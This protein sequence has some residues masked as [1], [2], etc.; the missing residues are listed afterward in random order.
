MP[1]LADA[2][3]GFVPTTDRVGVLLVL[4]EASR[5]RNLIARHAFTVDASLPERNLTIRKWLEEPT[6]PLRGVWFLPNTQVPG[7]KE[8]PDTPDRIRMPRNVVSAAFQ[9]AKPD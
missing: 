7:A 3:V 2:L 8:I 6:R 4:P 5:H 9:S 1:A